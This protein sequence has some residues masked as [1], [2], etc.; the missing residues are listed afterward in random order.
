[1]SIRM[2]KI[3][4]LLIRRLPLGGL[5]VVGFGVFVLAGS[6][7][8]V[9]FFQHLG[10]MESRVALE[11]LGRTNALFLEQSK[12][13]QS[14]HMASQLGRVMG[15]DVRFVDGGSEPA[16]GRAARI[17]DTLHVGF[18]L[19][20]GQQV[21]FAREAGPQG[22]RALWNRCDA[23]FALAGFWS[24]SLLFTL[25]LSRMVTRPL[26][27]L[28]AALPMIGGAAP[29]EPLPDRGPREI[30]RLATILRTTHEAILDEREKRHHAERLALLGRMAASFAHEVRNPV[31]AIR[32][33][34]QLIERA[35][36]SEGTAASARL[37]FAE[38]ARIET[39]VN[40]W[41]HYAKPEPITRVAVDVAALAS[42]VVDSLTPQATHAGVE[43]GMETRPA[44]A[45]RPGIS[46][47]RERL[48]QVLG[49][50]LLNAIQSMPMGGKV[51]VRVLPDSLEIDD[52]GG[53][54]SP[55]ALATF[56]RPFH[57]EREGGMGLGLAVS[58]EILDAHGASLHAENL[59]H[60][61]ARVR[62]GWHR[63]PPVRDFQS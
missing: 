46:G 32:L 3:H 43:I 20:S 7:A 63:P 13:P 44:P 27:K 53:G 16:D 5:L 56:A 62:V 8:L 15:A 55:A 9:G 29:P 35:G 6:V 51:A 39:L 38:A 34:A 31:S 26:A 61:G 18:P 37:V 57:S 25:W 19:A 24:L 42:E 49:N 33:H 28:E 1:M 45:G 17:G 54:F 52:Q 60:G 12:L 11:S 58:K 59:P 48:R 50:L 21:W 40:Q 14:A 2:D 23:R 36:R 22:I 41:L 30:V 4:P 47:D 10:Q